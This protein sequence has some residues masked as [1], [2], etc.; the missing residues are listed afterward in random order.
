MN[1]EVGDYIV[2]TA[3][4]YG[5]RYEIM[6]KVFD[7]SGDRFVVRNENNSDMSTLMVSRIGLAGWVKAA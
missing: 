3:D 7:P 2:H 5:E 6:E 1:F 4:P